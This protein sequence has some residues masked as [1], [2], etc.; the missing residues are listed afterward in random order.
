MINFIELPNWDLKIIIKNKKELKEFIDD[1]KTNIDNM[2][3][4]FQEID[5]E[6]SPYTYCT[7]DLIWQLSEM[8]IIMFNMWY[9][10]IWNPEFEK[11]WWFNDYMIKSE[12]QELIEN[13]EITFIKL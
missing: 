9:D 12:L 3:R 7:A 8:P 1:E 13:G 2:Y 10:D 6:N 4:L 11:I 5:S